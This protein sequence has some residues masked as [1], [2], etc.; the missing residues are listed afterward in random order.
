MDGKV[1]R[2][3]SLSPGLRLLVAAL[4]LGMVAGVIFCFTRTWTFL[5]DGSPYN[6]VFLSAALLLVL[7]AYVSEPFFTKPVDALVNSIALVI[8]LLGVRDKESFFG[9]VPA[10][11][12]AL[13]ML[14]L[15]VFVVA[16]PSGFLVRPKELSF[17]IVTGIGRSTVVFPVLYVLILA[18][19]S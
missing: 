19:R 6:L 18:L 13:L 15:S 9:F 7:G 1:D 16:S 8:A 11:I 5:G 2:R 12:V 17:R 10:L 14:L 3:R 4:L